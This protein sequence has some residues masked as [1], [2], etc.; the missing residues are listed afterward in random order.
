[1]FGCAAV[2]TVCAV[3]AFVAFV[4]SPLTFA[5]STAFAVAANDTSPVTFPPVRFAN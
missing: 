2:V 5:P 4:T 3:V 1:M